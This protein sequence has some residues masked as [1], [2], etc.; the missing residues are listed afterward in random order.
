M[1]QNALSPVPL[2]HQNVLSTYR[3]LR[4]VYSLRIDHRASLRGPLQ[5]ARPVCQAWPKDK[6]KPTISLASLTY[7]NWSQKYLPTMRYTS[8]V[9]D[10]FQFIVSLVVMICAHELFSRSNKSL[11][12]YSRPQ[13]EWFDPPLPAH[14]ESDDVRRYYHDPRGWSPLE[15]NC[16][17][18]GWIRS[19]Q[20][21]RIFQLCQEGL[22][23]RA[24]FAI[25]FGFQVVV[26]ASHTWIWWIEKKG[27]T[28]WMGQR[29]DSQEQLPD[30]VD[31]SE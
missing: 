10:A 6:R 14:G 31:R 23:A 4:C 17:L 7:V 8:V 26:L 13:P 3:C 20:Q 21:H 27:R 18:Q 15:W 11:K 5:V 25:L 22:A 29:L 16:G 9:L 28:P 24:L 12:Y 30:N 2:R 1:D 19:P